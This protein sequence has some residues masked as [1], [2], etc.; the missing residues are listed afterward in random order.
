VTAFESDPRDR[1]PLVA[2]VQRFGLIS[3]ATVVSRYA[4]IV[5]RA[6]GAG[7]TTTAVPG[8]PG[9]ERD[10]LGRTAPRAAEAALR[11]LDRA[12]ALAAGATTASPAMA[13]HLALPAATPGDS[14]QVSVWLHNPTPAPVVTRVQVTCLVSGCGTVIPVEAVTC[15]PS[16]DVRLAP[17]GAC[18]VLVRVRVPAGQPTGHYH[19]LVV[20]SVAPEPMRLA[21]HVAGD[22]SAAP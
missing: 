10:W 11:L 15:E 13:E 6:L 3:A 14:V 22:R 16:D 12:T 4:A 20:A 18:A 21:L 17:T 2:D 1:E 7:A 19:G 5:D 9:V 8:R